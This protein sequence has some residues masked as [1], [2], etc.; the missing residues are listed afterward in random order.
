LL[1][2]LGIM[3]HEENQQ[4]T[5]PII[6]TGPK[7]S[8]TYFGEI[9]SFIENTLGS[10]ALKL[11]EIIIDD[12]PAVARKL[13]LAAAEVRHYRK[14]VGDA[15]H[16]NWTLQVEPAFQQPFIPN[17]QNM[18]ALDLHLDQDSATLAANLRRAFSGIVA[19]N[20][21]DEGI[22]AIR[23]HGPF[24][25]SGEPKLMQMMDTL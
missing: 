4:Q 8:E 9:A 17:H 24:Q 23:Q 22:K 1:Y 18:A 13:K 12:A 14:S 20:V 15:Y 25:I 7:Q 11:I 5:L 21:K 19:G 3:L 2:L 6:L 10:E 16:F